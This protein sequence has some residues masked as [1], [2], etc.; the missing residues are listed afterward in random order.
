MINLIT[1]PCSDCIDMPTL[2]N[3]SSGCSD[4]DQWKIVRLE[5]EVRELK[6]TVKGMEDELKGM[7]EEAHYLGYDTA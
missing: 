7:E 4:C 3:I 6:E 2:H 1:T 5:D